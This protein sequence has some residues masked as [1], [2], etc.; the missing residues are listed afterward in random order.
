MDAGAR[1]GW[2]SC[3]NLGTCRLTRTKARP[4]PP[5]S[6]EVKTISNKTL[7]TYLPS[8]GHQQLVH[9]RLIHRLIPPLHA[10]IRAGHKPIHAIRQVRLDL[11]VERRCPVAKEICNIC[12]CD[13]RV[14]KGEEGGRCAV[15]ERVGVTD[16][17]GG[18]GGC[19]EDDFGREVVLEV[20]ADAGEF[21]D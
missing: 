11:I 16:R 17:G 5:I 3:R 20:G 9:R 1:I 14:Y 8:L 7:G 12:I 15:F 2:R 4:A 13:S 19:A 6:H 18:F 10:L 21:V